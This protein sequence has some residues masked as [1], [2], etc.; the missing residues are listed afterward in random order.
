MHVLASS[1]GNGELWLIR[2]LPMQVASETLKLLHSSLAILA[3]EGAEA[4]AEARCLGM[5]VDLLVLCA[6]PEGSSSAGGLLRELV[7]KLM[8]VLASGAS[9]PA[10]R[11]ALLALPASS[12]ERLQ[13][14]PPAVFLQACEL[15]E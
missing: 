3:A 5:L 7:G 8:T 12:R 10:F 13:V 6:A 15:L 11:N 4:E 2:G 14:C 9:G 1:V